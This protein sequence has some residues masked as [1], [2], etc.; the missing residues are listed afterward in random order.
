MNYCSQCG[1]KLVRGS[2]FC[3]KCGKSVKDEQIVSRFETQL[4][5]FR[6]NSK[7]AQYLETFI[8]N[9]LVIVFAFIVII[10]MI[11][12]I[13]PILGWL[14]FFLGIIF[15]YWYANSKNSSE[16][17]WNKKVKE[18]VKSIDKEEIREF[19][20][21]LLQTATKNLTVTKEYIEPS[22]NSKD[23][24]SADE[25]EYHDES[26]EIQVDSESGKIYYSWLVSLIGIIFYYTGVFL[27][28]ILHGEISGLGYGLDSTITLYDYLTLLSKMDGGYQFMLIVIL[29]IPMISFIL[30]FINHVISKFFQVLL[31][32]ANG[33]FLFKIISEIKTY[34]VS[35]EYFDISSS[36]SIGF[37][38]LLV[39]MGI[40][41]MIVTTIW[42]VIKE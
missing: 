16:Q 24:V 27:A 38:I 3:E 25:N 1:E 26:V 8:K 5:V 18:T 42:K 22:L 14:L 11:L 4:N 20:N 29:I 21:G 37:G 33:L 15:S 34:S 23:E 2:N 19:A 31:L 32:I 35:S 36:N 6:L 17:L 30:L 28:P 7:K 9:N 12:S 39:G 41:L 13:Q 40:I 10:M